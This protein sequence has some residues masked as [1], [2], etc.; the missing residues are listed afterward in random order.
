MGGSNDKFEELQTQVISLMAVCSILS[1]AIIE[2][3]KKSYLVLNKRQQDFLIDTL[4]T[5]EQYVKTLRDEG[6][7]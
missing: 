2:T 6:K 5:F 1:K 3:D 4:F 7:Q